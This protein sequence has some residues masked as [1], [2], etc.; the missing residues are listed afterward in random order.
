MKMN[1]KKLYAE[2][3][4]PTPTVQTSYPK[5]PVLLVLYLGNVSSEEK[6]KKCNLGDGLAC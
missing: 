4:E 3:E 6:K 2:L 5:N 1:N